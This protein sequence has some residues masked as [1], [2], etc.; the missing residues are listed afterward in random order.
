[1][2]TYA[3]QRL[4]DPQWLEELAQVIER[5]KE[6]VV[7]HPRGAL[8]PVLQFVQREL[9]YLPEPVIRRV[10]DELDVSPAEVYGVASFYT[11]F[12]LEPRG[13]YMVSVCLG[14]ACYVSGSAHILDR[15]CELLEISPGE[16][17]ADGLFTVRPVRCL[18]CC[19]RAA[20]VMVNER[21]HSRVTPRD[22]PRIIS[23]YR[24]EAEGGAME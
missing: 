22:V 7:G 20:A 14:T 4:D 17:S 15:F 6:L 12:S 1:M 24:R 23:A 11:F 19:S 21:V 13:L 3:Q 2:A 8:I 16:T 9:G 10:A 18:G 5:E